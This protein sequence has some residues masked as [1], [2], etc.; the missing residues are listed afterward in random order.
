M[1]MKA[2]GMMDCGWQ[3]SADATATAHRLQQWS[4]TDVLHRQC[5]GAQ[6]IRW[7]FGQEVRGEWADQIKKRRDDGSQRE[8][9]G[10]DGNYGI[11]ELT[12]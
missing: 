7:S 2:D 9:K 10:D 12:S 11:P 6:T 8:G 1:A 3:K 5:T 4:I